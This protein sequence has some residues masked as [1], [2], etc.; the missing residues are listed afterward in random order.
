MLAQGCLM[1]AIHTLNAVACRATPSDGSPFIYYGQS[2][3]LSHAGRLYHQTKDGHNAILN[4]LDHNAQYKATLHDC[5]Y[6]DPGPPSTRINA[7][8]IF[9]VKYDTVYRITD[10]TYFNYYNYVK[11]GTSDRM[12]YIMHAVR[13]LQ[14]FWRARRLMRKCEV[15]L[16]HALYKSEQPT[17]LQCVPVDILLQ[18]R[19]EAMAFV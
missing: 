3:M 16:L 18:I 13:R 8:H 10:N 19:N 7:R 2:R 4:V 1:S 17:W 5:V 15:L 9:L 6:V 14:R 12:V 11:S